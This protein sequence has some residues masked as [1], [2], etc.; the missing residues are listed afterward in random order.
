MANLV[1]QT[2]GNYKLVERLS[3]L[4]SHRAFLFKEGMRDPEKFIPYESPSDEWLTQVVDRLR[5]KQ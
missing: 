5:Q 4:G 3:E 2:L 1:G